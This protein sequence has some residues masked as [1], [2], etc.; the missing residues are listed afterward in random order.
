MWEGITAVCAVLALALSVIVFLRTL[1]PRG[2]RHDD[3][4]PGG[5]HRT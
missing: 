2:R 5:N 1:R 4:G 3:D